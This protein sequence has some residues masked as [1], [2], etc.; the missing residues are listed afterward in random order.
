MPSRLQIFVIVLVIIS[1][2]S[3]VSIR[4]YNRLEFVELQN[5]QKRHDELQTEWGRLMLEKATWTGQHTVA[6]AARKQLAMNAPSPDKIITVQT[7]PDSSDAAK[8]V[9][10]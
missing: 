6:D 3:V 7:L 10:E 9:V 2:A 1:A 4:H 8:Q 5:Q